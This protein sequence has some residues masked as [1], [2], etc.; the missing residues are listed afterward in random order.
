MIEFPQSEYILYYK[1][2]YIM[3]TSSLKKK[4][5]EHNLLFSYSVMVMPT[6]NFNFHIIQHT[7]FRITDLFTA[8]R[9]MPNGK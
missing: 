5:N 7:D 8:S 6:D 3:L 4:N 2:K 9:Q 1:K